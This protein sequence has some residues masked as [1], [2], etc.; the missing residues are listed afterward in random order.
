MVSV[1]WVLFLCNFCGLT[2]P[3]SGEKRGVKLLFRV[4]MDAKKDVSP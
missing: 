4:A 1:F 3:M 2:K